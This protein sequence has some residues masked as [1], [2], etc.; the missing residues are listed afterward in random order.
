M[1]W[2]WIKSWTKGTICWP[3]LSSTIRK[4]FMSLRKSIH[5][6]RWVWILTSLTMARNWS[7]VFWQSCFDWSMLGSSQI[8]RQFCAMCRLRRI[9]S[10]CDAVKSFY[11]YCCQ[12]LVNHQRV[13]RNNRLLLMYKRIFCEVFLFDNVVAPTA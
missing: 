7:N 10:D 2:T 12:S 5:S 6:S 13:I 4:A 1:A 11:L 8:S 3:T 9:L